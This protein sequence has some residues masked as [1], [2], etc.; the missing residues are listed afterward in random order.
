MMNLVLKLSTEN[1][2]KCKRRHTFNGRKISTFF[3]SYPFYH[4][5]YLFI[6]IVFAFKY[7]TASLLFLH[8]FNLLL[9]VYVL[10]LLC[11]VLEPTDFKHCFWTLKGLLSV[12]VSCVKRLTDPNP[13]YSNLVFGILEAGRW[14][15]NKHE[16]KMNLGDVLKKIEQLEWFEL[17]VVIGLKSKWFCA[18]CPACF[19]T[20]FFSGFHNRNS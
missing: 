13:W 9:F 6:F 7:S 20:L 14:K 2:F 16:T 3:V 19:A 10:L 17:L 1:A 18:F 12:R 15:D 11:C 8:C 4:K 5:H